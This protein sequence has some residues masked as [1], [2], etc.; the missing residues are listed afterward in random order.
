MRS[1]GSSA[2]A[3]PCTPSYVFAFFREHAEWE[4]LR[5]RRRMKGT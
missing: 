2:A 4:L 5:K 1:S 3:L